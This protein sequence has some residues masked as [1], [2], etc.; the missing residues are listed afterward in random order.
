VPFQALTLLPVH[1]REIHQDLIDDV[2]VFVTVRSTFRPL[3]QSDVTFTPTVSAAGDPVAGEVVAV[4]VGV[5]VVVG[6]AVG[7][8][9]GV[10]V[11]VGVGVAAAPMTE[12]VPVGIVQLAGL[13]AEPLDVAMN[14]K[15][16]EPPGARLVFHDGPVKR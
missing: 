3:P 9:V 15:L 2:D 8:T 16:A 10:G 14:P 11:G 6:V 7:V 1:G 13:T 5:D 12:Q 4:G